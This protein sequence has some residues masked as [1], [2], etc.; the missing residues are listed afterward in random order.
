MIF[1]SNCE[2]GTHMRKKSIVPCYQSIMPNV[3]FALKELGGTETY[4]RVLYKVLFDLDISPSSFKQARN[5]ISWAGTYLRKLDIL[6]K[7]TKQG[8][9]VLK[10][11]FMNMDNQQIK[12][13]I[14]KRYKKYY[15]L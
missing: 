7:G 3:V 12:E 11:E 2:R 5:N 15:N 10:S 4:S 1:L 6:E 14:K 9:W 13:E 8:V